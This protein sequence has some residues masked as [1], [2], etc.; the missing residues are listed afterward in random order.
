MPKSKEEILK[1][2]IR[3]HGEIHQIIDDATVWN[4]KFRKPYQRPIEIDPDGE[5]QK[6]HDAAVKIIKEFSPA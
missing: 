3:I 5:M 6:A 4:E 1:E 2:A